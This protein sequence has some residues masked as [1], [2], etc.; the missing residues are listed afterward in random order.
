MVTCDW[1]SN[2]LCDLRLFRSGLLTPLLQYSGAP[3]NCSSMMCETFSHQRQPGISGHR[4]LL[5]KCHTLLSSASLWIQMTACLPS[6]TLLTQRA[7]GFCQE[8][9]CWM[10]E[11]NSHLCCCVLQG[12]SYMKNKPF[13]LL[14]ITLNKLTWIKQV[15]NCISSNSGGTKGILYINKTGFQ[16]ALS[17]VFFGILHFL[18]YSFI[19]SLHLS[20]VIPAKCAGDNT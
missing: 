5:V 12:F 9:L 11:S 14:I 3:F 19:N 10:T 7:W 1:I 20:A 2:A 13:P 8:C 17:L 6:A 16:K 4:R 15:Q 18:L